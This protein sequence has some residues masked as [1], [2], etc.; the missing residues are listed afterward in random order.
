MFYYNIKEYYFFGWMYSMNRP[1]FRSSIDEI[2]KIFEERNIG[3]DLSDI[4]NELTFRKSKRAKK[5]YTRI[6]NDKI[7]TKDNAENLNSPIE[8]NTID[9]KTYENI[10]VVGDDDDDDNVSIDSLDE[11]N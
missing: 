1:F 6:K 7:K 3:D 11:E 2:E 8:T 5:F 9:K 10:S 4:V